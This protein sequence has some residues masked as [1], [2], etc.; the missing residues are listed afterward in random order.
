MGEN[1]NT[2]QDVNHRKLTWLSYLILK[3]PSKAIRIFLRR[4]GCKGHS[5]LYP[6]PALAIQRFHQETGLCKSMK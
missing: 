5:Q 3:L 2:S 6:D 4:G 1:T